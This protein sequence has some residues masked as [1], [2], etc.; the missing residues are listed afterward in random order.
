MRTSLTAF[1]AA[2]AALTATLA[3]ALVG[4]TSAPAGAEQSSSS[5]SVGSVAKTA[6]PQPVVAKQLFTN[7]VT[8]G[9]FT[10]LGFDQCLAPEQWKMDAW[11][12]ASP[13]RAVG[14]YIS[15]DSRGCRNQPNLTPT[16]VATQ[17]AK[18]WHLLPIT[19]GPQASCHPSFPRYGNDPVISTKLNKNGQYA[20]AGRQGRDEATKAVAAAQALGI[21]PGSTLFYDLE[22]FSITNNACRESA[23]N[24]LSAWTQQLHALGYKSGVYSSAGSGIKALDDARVTRP[25]AFALPDIIWIARWDGKA[26]TSTDYIRPDGWLPGRRLKQFQGGHKETWGGVTINID[27]NYLDLST[28][29]RMA[30]PTACGSTTVDLPRY[31]RVKAPA[32]GKIPDP[33]Q[34][35]VLKCL[36]KKQGYFKGKTKGAWSPRLTK[37]VKKWQSDHGLKQSAVFSR[38]AWVTLLAAGPTPVLNLGSGGED[39]RRV[40]RALN[41]TKPAA[42]LVVTG[43]YDLETQAAVAVWQAKH[44]IGENGIFGEQSWA[45]LQ[46]GK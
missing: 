6:A 19:L 40:Q 10:G 31:R 7:P 33:A 32:K 37:A 4:L 20:K 28:G 44:G 26:N 25:D 27:R 3:T 30:P 2:T 17:L 24:F 29:A 42:K 46:T 21:V 15:G 13:F 39:V 18:G 11:L 34:V 43:T 41:T 16:W 36:L 38:N 8:P 22:G 35:S 12:K 45:K 14:I 9:D 5:A 1:V 23:L